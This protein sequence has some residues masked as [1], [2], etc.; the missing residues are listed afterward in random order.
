M[1]KTRN[2]TK[3]ARE[4][5]LEV[6]AEAGGDATDPRTPAPLTTRRLAKRLGLSMH[7]VRRCLAV[8]TDADAYERMQWTAG[9]P[10]KDTGL[11]EAARAWIT[12]RETLRSQVGKALTTRMMIANQRFDLTMTLAEFRTV[13]KKARI[14]RQKVTPLTIPPRMPDA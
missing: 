6:L 12:D 1:P 11:T 9:R 5:L 7:Q 4:K 8:V 3:P 14:T 10:K 13:Y 2:K